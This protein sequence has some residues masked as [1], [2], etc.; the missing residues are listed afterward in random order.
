MHVR[1]AARGAVLVLGDRAE[2]GVVVD[3]DRA[4]EPAPELLG[5]SQLVPARQHRVVDAGGAAVDRP[6]HAQPDS[7]QV[8]HGDSGVLRRLP[9]QVG[10]EVER[11]GALWVRVGRHLEL[12]EDA[13]AAIGHRYPDVAVTDV[14]TGHAPGSQRESHEQR[15]PPAAALVR[16]SAVSG[17][18]DDAGREQ[19]GD[20]ARDRGA[21]ES[22]A[23]GQVGAALWTARA[24]ERGD[25]VEVA[26][27]QLGQGVSGHGQKTKPIPP[28]AVQMT[29]STAASSAL[30]R[31][32]RDP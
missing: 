1:D 10:R 23:T 28:E 24:E 20:Q 29:T 12:G 18:H 15:W 22:R 7:E 19:L 17:L 27:A 30:T 9:H 32:N 8:G 26:A 6:R 13:G 16:R 31:T 3:H 2:V 4:T 25:R 5:G 11:G 21:R 14:D